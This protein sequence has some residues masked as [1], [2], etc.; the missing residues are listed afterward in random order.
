MNSVGKGLAKTRMYS[1]P[2]T[3]NFLFKMEWTGSSYY[4]KKYAD[5]KIVTTSSKSNDK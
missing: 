2:I 3:L 1:E 4:P 5:T